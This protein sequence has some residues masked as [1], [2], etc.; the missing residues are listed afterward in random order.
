[1]ALSNVQHCFAF[2]QLSYKTIDLLCNKELSGRSPVKYIN[3]HRFFI[4]VSNVK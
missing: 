3:L 2:L 4:M 1:M